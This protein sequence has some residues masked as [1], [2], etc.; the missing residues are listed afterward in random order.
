MRLFGS[1]RILNMVNRL[2]LPD[3]QPIDAK[4]LSNSI[5]SA[6]KR[7]EDQ[8]FSRRKH[9]LEYDDVMNQQRNII[10]AQRKEVLDGAD[11]HEKILSMMENT[12][13]EL[14]NLSTASEL[15]EEWNFE[16]IRQDLMPL[17]TAED[18]KYTNEELNKLTA[19][20]IKSLLLER[21]RALYEQKEA[22]FAEAGMDMREIERVILLQ[23]VDTHWMAHLDNM[24]AL[25]G[26]VGLNAYA[27]R[28]PITEYRI[29]GADMF[30]AM[31]AEIREDTVRALWA[32]VP[33][34]APVERRSV[35]KVTAEGFE[36]AAAKKKPSVVRAGQ[37]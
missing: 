10:Y 5:E 26:G 18:F 32:V 34:K 25:K 31:V 33:R 21:A 37:R 19:Q 28:N 4:I 20:D 14:V 15:P 7:L 16:Q 27:Q 29:A 17:C 1:E 9:V 35:A 23:S 12:I 2:G 13:D 22:M 3:D 11:L 30:D 8:N 24:D 36:G 6:Q